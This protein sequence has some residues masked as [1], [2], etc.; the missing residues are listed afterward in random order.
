MFFLALRHLLSRKKQTILTLLGI[1]L[2]T[3]AYIT[4]SAMMLGFQFFIIDQLVN[5]DSHIRVKA[6]EETLTAENLKSYLF[7]DHILVKW[8]KPPSVRK[9][10]SSILAPQM[11]LDR[12]TSDERVSAASSQLVIQ[13]IAN[14]GKLSVGVSI[15]GSDPERQISVSNI[16]ASMLEGRFIDIG[17]S[18]HR[19]AVGDEFLKKIGASRGETILLT[20][21]KGLPQ[22]FRIV[23][24]FHLD[25]HP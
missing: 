6:R 18:G 5:N 7:E 17:V 3:A 15:V 22:P 14:Y 25:C 19:I 12:I 21:G 23:S 11:W 13:G 2:G 24:I 1:I 10:N 16:E 9:D 4:I 8:I 20:V